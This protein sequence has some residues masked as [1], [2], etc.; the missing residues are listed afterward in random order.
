MGLPE[1]PPNFFI[2]SPNWESVGNRPG[3]LRDRVAALRPAL[4]VLDPLRVFYPK[5]ETGTDEAVTMVKELRALS[6]QYGCAWILLHHRRK[7]NQ[8]PNVSAASLLNDPH[9]WMQEAAGSHALVNQSDT[10][11]GIDTCADA[12]LV[13]TG[14]VRGRGVATPIY[15]DRVF[16]DDGEPKGYLPVEGVRLL[17]YEERD[18][19]DALPD[20]FRFKDLKEGCGGGG[21]KSQR[22]LNRF[23]GLSLVKK[24]D[25]QYLK[26]PQPDT[27]LPARRTP[28]SYL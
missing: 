15:L 20:T 16:D 1:P 13:V 26:I 21:S 9:G 23:I 24:N 11:L 14:I 12:D 2:H 22:I 25:S 5:A 19:F 8:N 7:A 27:P 17:E 6:K 18:I 3:S 4:V 10:R 28:D